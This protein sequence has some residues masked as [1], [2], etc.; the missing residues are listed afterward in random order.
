[1]QIHEGTRWGFLGPLGEL[2]VNRLEL[3]VHICPSCGKTEF[4]F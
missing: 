4:F 3:E 2:M 1:M